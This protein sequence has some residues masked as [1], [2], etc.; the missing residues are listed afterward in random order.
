[1]GTP[2]H[3]RSAK[4]DA[5]A[6]KTHTPTISALSGPVVHHNGRVKNLVQKLHLRKKRFSARFV[7]NCG[8]LSLRV[9]ETSTTELPNSILHCLDHDPVVET[10]TGV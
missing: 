4:N 10:S 7:T 2:V 5:N 6:P 8:N 9:T 1:M 3:G